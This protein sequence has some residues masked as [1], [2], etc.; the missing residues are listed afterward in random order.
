MTHCTLTRR[1]LVDDYFSSADLYALGVAQSTGNRF[2]T[3]LQWISRI[4]LMI[5]C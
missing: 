5:E 1:I 2:V 3:F 4:G